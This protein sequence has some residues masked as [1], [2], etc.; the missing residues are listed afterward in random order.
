MSPDRPAP[1]SDAEPLPASGDVRAQT[2][3]QAAALTGLPEISAGADLPDLILRHPPRWPDGTTGLAEGDI[4]V[5]TSKVV[6]KAAGLLTSRPREEVI[7]EQT[8]D[9][10]AERRAPGAAGPT[11]IARTR[12]GLV[13]AAAG[14]D[15][16]NTPPGTC[17]PLPPD[18]D[19]DA[20]RLRAALQQATGLRLGVIISDTLGRP[21]RIGQTDAAI[22]AAGLAPSI[23]MAGRTDPQ[24]NPLQV[25]EPAV[26][27][28]IAGTAEL[29][30]G[31]TSGNPVVV[32]RGLGGLLSME[33]GPGAAA[34]IRPAE[35]DLFRLGTAEAIAQGR[36]EAPFHRRTIR[37]FA[38]RRVD[39]TRIEAAV[40]AAITA[41]S[42]HHSTPWRFV[43]LT[44]GDLRIRLLDAMRQAWESDLRTIDRYPPTAVAKRV[45][46][47]DILRRAPE[48]VLPFQDLAAAAH[49]YPD[50]RRRGFERDLFLV[51]GGA[52]VQNLLVALAGEGLGAAWISSTMFC[53]EVVREV[54]ELP[55]AWQPLGAVAIGHPAAQAPARPARSVGT[56]LIRR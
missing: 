20:R 12:H 44:D 49:S 17:L 41:P 27:D 55:E 11:R 26:A 37:A 52:A 3:V 14:V 1:G 9:V 54:L 42:P 35:A 39:H 43:H 28:E 53:P 22:G 10:V 5:I 30:S 33:D 4:L 8:V 48:V 6:S 36:R 56:F 18:P 19:G 32:V 2:G 25:T 34:L 50:E 51:A 24:G 15:A 13:L 7:A 21:W 46:R 16:S 47:G 31:K 23:P 40:A 45:A 29:V 38:D